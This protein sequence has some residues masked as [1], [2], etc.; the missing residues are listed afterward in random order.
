MKGFL[1][2]LKVIVRLIFENQV[3]TNNKSPQ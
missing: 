3:F 1:R 2:L